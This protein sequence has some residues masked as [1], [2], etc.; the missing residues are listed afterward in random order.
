MLQKFLAMHSKINRQLYAFSR[1]L[2]FFTKQVSIIDFINHLMLL[3]ESD[4][5]PY[6]KRPVDV[7][8]KLAVAESKKGASNSIIGKKYSLIF[9][10]ITQK[11]RFEQIIFVVKKGRLKKVISLC[12][13]SETSRD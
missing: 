8:L 6:K 9:N 11:Y 3:I 12:R 2:S 7:V 10:K 13:V 4:S 1:F 5:D